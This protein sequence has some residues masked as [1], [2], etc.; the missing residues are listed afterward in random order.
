MSPFIDKVKIA[1]S[2][3]K[4]YP[5]SPKRDSPLPGTPSTKVGAA[6]QP[7]MKGEYGKL[8]VTPEGDVHHWITDE[9]GA[10]HHYQYAEDHGLTYKT[11]RPHGHATGY[12]DPDGTLHVPDQMYKERAEP[13]ARAALPETHPPKPGWI[14]S[15]VASV[16]VQNGGHHITNYLGSPSDSI[17]TSWKPG[18]RGKGL[19]LNDGLHMWNSMSD[20]FDPHHDGIYNH[21]R[22]SDYTDAVEHYGELNAAPKFYIDYDGT[23]DMSLKGDYDPD[24]DDRIAA[25]HPDLKVKDSGW[26]FSKIATV[27]ENTW[28]RGKWGKGLMLDGDAWFW[29][30]DRAGAPHHFAYNR[31]TLQ[32]GDRY[33]DAIPLLIKPDGYVDIYAFPTDGDMS[34]VEAQIKLFGDDWPRYMKPG[35]IGNFYQENKIENPYALPAP[36]DWLFSQASIADD[37]GIDEDEDDFDEDQYL[38]DEGWLNPMQTLDR[39]EPL[40]HVDHP[41]PSGEHYDTKPDDY[42]DVDEST[43][44][45]PVLFDGKRFYAGRVN[46]YH[47]D[48]MHHDP[49]LRAQSDQGQ[50]MKGNPLTALDDKD[51]FAYGR[52]NEKNNAITWYHKG[53]WRRD[54]LNTLTDEVFGSPDDQSEDM[55]FKDDDWHFGANE[56]TV[57]IQ[58]DKDKF[59]PQDFSAWY[60]PQSN[61]VDTGDQSMHHMDIEHP[62]EAIAFWAYNGELGTYGGAPLWLDRVAEWLQTQGAMTVLDGGG[63]KFAAQVTPQIKEVSES[64]MDDDSY[65]PS[66]RRPVLYY[67][68]HNTVLVGPHDSHHD[69]LYEYLGDD[70]DP[71]E[72][73]S[74]IM[75]DNKLRFW[76]DEEKERP[77]AAEQALMKQYG[78]ELDKDS[79]EWEFTAAVDPEITEVPYDTPDM[80]WPWVAQRRPFIYSPKHGTI[81]MTEFGGHHGGIHKWLK[82]NAPHVLD[83][84][85]YEGMVNTDPKTP[86]EG[87]GNGNIAY[88]GDVPGD[89]QLVQNAI[90]NKFPEYKWPD[91]RQEPAGNNEWMFGHVAGDHTD[92]QWAYDKTKVVPW[93]PEANSSGKFIVEPDGKVHHWVVDRHG[94]PHHFQYAQD[95]LGHKDIPI[96]DVPEDHVQGWITPSGGIDGWGDESLVQ[97]AKEAIHGHDQEDWVFGHTSAIPVVEYPGTERGGPGQL[98]PPMHGVKSRAVTYLNGI[99]HVGMP[100]S[101]H[102]FA[103]DPDNESMS[104]RIYPEE[105]VFEW[106]DNPGNVSDQEVIEALAPYGVKSVLDGVWHGGDQPSKVDEDLNWSYSRVNPTSQVDIANAFASPEDELQLFARSLSNLTQS[107]IQPKVQHGSQAGGHNSQSSGRR[108]TYQAGNASSELQPISSLRNRRAREED[109]ALGQPVT[110]TTPAPFKEPV[111]GQHWKGL[112]LNNGEEYRWWVDG[113]WGAPHHGDAMATLNIAPEE[114]ANYLDSSRD[115]KTGFD[116]DYGERTPSLQQPFVDMGKTNWTFS[117]TEQSWRPGEIGKFLVSPRGEVWS[118]ITEDDAAGGSPHHSDY[119][120]QHGLPTAKE[121]EADWLFGFIEP[122]GDYEANGPEES[123]RIAER[124]LGVKPMPD[125]S[126]TFGAVDSQTEGNRILKLTDGSVVEQDGAVSSHMMLAHEFGIHPDN[127]ADTG[128]IRNGEYEWDNTPGWNEERRNNTDWAFSKTANDWSFVE[129]PEEDTESALIL[130]DDTMRQ[131]NTDDYEAHHD[132]MKAHGLT[133]ADV[134]DYGWI[135]PKGHY[136]SLTGNYGEHQD[137]GGF[138]QKG[139][140]DYY[141]DAWKHGAT[142]ATHREAWGLKRKKPEP[143]D[144][145]FAPQ[146]YI[147]GVVMKNDGAVRSWDTEKTGEY[148]HDWLENNGIDPASVVMWRTDPYEDDKLEID[149]D[150]EKH[151]PNVLKHLQ[152]EHGIS[153]EVREPWTEKTDANEQYAPQVYSQHNAKEKQEGD[154]L[155]RE[156]IQPWMPRE[157]GKWLLDPYGKVHHWAYNGRG[158]PHHSDV[159]NYLGY[160]IADNWEEWPSGEIYPDGG[161]VQSYGS[162]RAQAMNAVLAQVQGTHAAEDKGDWTYSRSSHVQY[163]QDTQIGSNMNRANG[164]IRLNYR[165]SLPSIL[166]SSGES[167]QFIPWT[168]GNKGKYIVSPDNKVHHWT[169]DNKG[170]PHHE[171]WARAQ[172][173]YSEPWE[174]WPYGYIEPDGTYSIEPGMDAGYRER[175]DI[176]ALVTGQV[177]GTV[178]QDDMNTSDDWQFTSKRYAHLTVRRPSYKGFLVSETLAYPFLSIENEIEDTSASG[179][180]DTG[181]VTSWYTARGVPVSSEKAD[182]IFEISSNTHH[183][184][185]K[186]ANPPSVEL[187]YGTIE[188]W[189]KGKYGKAM[190]DPKGNIYAWATDVSSPEEDAGIV[191]GSPHHGEVAGILFG[192]NYYMMKITFVYMYPDGKV[193]R[194]GRDDSSNEMDIQKIADALGGYMPQDEDWSFNFSKTAAFA[195]PEGYEP[196]KP[197]GFGKAI[198]HNGNHYAWATDVGKSTGDPRNE[199]WIGAPHHGEALRDLDIRNDPVAKHYIYPDGTVDPSW[200]KDPKNHQYAAEIADHI[201]G[202]TGEPD[203]TFSKTAEVY[204]PIPTP[205]Y[206]VPKGLDPPEIGRWG[207]AINRRD[208]GD[209]YAWSTN[210]NGEPHHAYVARDELKLGTPPYHVDAFEHIVPWVIDDKGQWFLA[211]DV[212]FDWRFAKT[213][214]AETPPEFEPWTPGHDGKGLTVKDGTVYAWNSAG[215]G[216]GKR[217]H[218]YDALEAIYGIRARNLVL[219]YF[220]IRDDEIINSASPDPEHGLPPAV[221]ALGIPLKN[222]GNWTF[223]KIAK[224]E[225]PSVNHPEMGYRLMGTPQPWEPGMYGKGWVTPEGIVYLWGQHIA[226]AQSVTPHHA[227]MIPVTTGLA[228]YGDQAGQA[229][230]H[231]DKTFLVS[232][233]GTVSPSVHIRNV[234]EFIDTILA[235]DPRLK[236]EK[237]NEAWTFSRVGHVLGWEPGEEGRALKL[238][239]GTVHT[240]GGGIWDHGSIYHGDYAD[241]NGLEYDGPQAITD[242]LYIHNDGH[243]SGGDKDTNQYVQD[244]IGTQQPSGEDDWTFSKVASLPVTNGNLTYTEYEPP[245]GR[246]T[247]PPWEPGKKGKGILTENGIYFWAT[248]SLGAPHHG[249]INTTVGGKELGFCYINPDGSLRTQGRNQEVFEKALP[250]THTAPEQDWTFSRVAAEQRLEWTPGMYGRALTMGDGSIYTWNCGE[251]EGEVWSNAGGYHNAYINKHKIPYQPDTQYMYIEPNGA[252]TDG[253]NDESEM[254]V[255]KLNGYER[256]ADKEDDDWTFGKVAEQ[257]Q[258]LNLYP[259][260]PPAKPIEVVYDAGDEADDFHS[261]DHPFIYDPVQRKVWVGHEGAYHWDLVQHPELSPSYFYN[262]GSKKPGRAPAM[263]NRS[264]VNGRYNARNHNVEWFDDV[265]GVAKVPQK[266]KVEVESALGGSSAGESAWTFGKVAV[267]GLKQWT[268]GNL[269]KAFVTADGNA[270]AW[271][272]RPGKT[273]KEDGLP[274]HQD[275]MKASGYGSIWDAF[276]TWSF[277]Y[278]GADGT[279]DQVSDPEDD[280]AAAKRHNDALE[281]LGFKPAS[282]DASWSFSK[283][284]SAI[285]P[286]TMKPWSPNKEGKGFVTPDGK[287]YAWAVTVMRS[288]HHMDGWENVFGPWDPK[289]T[290]GPIA[291]FYTDRGKI[292][293]ATGGTDPHRGLEI[294]AQELGV[295][296]DNGTTT[297]NFARTAATKVIDWREDQLDDPLYSNHP[298]P[299]D[300]NQ[301]PNKPW[302]YNREKDEIHIGPDNWFHADLV[303]GMRDNW[304]NYNSSGRL[305]LAH[306]HGFDPE[307]E[308]IY[309]ALKDHYGYHNEDFDDGSS[310]DDRWDFESRVAVKALVPQGCRPWTRGED[311]RYLVDGHGAVWAWVADDSTHSEVEMDNDLEAVDGGYIT[312]DGK[313]LPWDGGEQNWIFSAVAPIKMKVV[314]PNDDNVDEYNMDDL[315]DRRPV[316]FNPHTRQGYIGDYGW[317]HTGIFNQEPDLDSDN[318]LA[319]T[320]YTDWKY[321]TLRDDEEGGHMLDWY[322][323]GNPHRDDHEP[324]RAAISEALGAPVTRRDTDD[325]WTFGKVA[326]IPPI[327]DYT[328][329]NQQLNDGR[330]RAVDGEELWELLREGWTPGKEGKGLL[331]D[332]E[333]YTWNTTNDMG[334]PHH[335]EMATVLEAAGVRIRQPF[336]IDAIYPDGGIETNESAY[337]IVH[338]HDP[339]LHK[340]EQQSMFDVWNFR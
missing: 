198:T 128:W 174:D 117:G 89:K 10:P 288:A 173:I 73:Y 220:Y 270:V 38:E 40:R 161:V 222:E 39:S 191:W 126:W 167:H 32:L 303:R 136:V 245:H 334:D 308:K 262:D 283:V 34:R 18:G 61:S 86:S 281:A 107:D 59:D 102:G 44:E 37:V 65:P 298:R 258:M 214:S 217:D 172:G 287:V 33:Y 148:H 72:V 160:T 224:V 144:Y 82:A 331:T 15:K 142:V 64:T 243:V 196:W 53:K 151:A 108:N 156:E 329:V 302:L 124:E 8:L 5:P 183:Y 111:P 146:H 184:A 188:P 247:A 335:H 319:D 332:G 1:P 168:P 95:Y 289:V 285:T 255:E 194:A 94:A 9:N 35:N 56:L 300:S 218:H 317:H 106:Y 337:D 87:N 121:P 125:K 153:P 208:N 55:G 259:D 276:S 175:D 277:Y 279:Y 192:P 210:G 25:M 264:L 29:G 135:H 312:P 170:F 323:H 48:M 123:K 200:R 219:A 226:E 340:A 309:E 290:V 28:Q 228:G 203:W 315:G 140:W 215:D 328:R 178:T 110:F 242:H 139:N 122:N 92:D 212:P 256:P 244:V 16:P 282:S 145:T 76:N 235:A 4:V 230:E 26:S 294:A 171:Q 150:Q 291:W 166:H 51:K 181:Q 93:T 90:F 21:L 163:L 325:D 280:P 206:E 313:K 58:G 36:G 3:P 101:Y 88:W 67:P 19:L 253:W 322:S 127:I 314:E 339:R 43:H 186:L 199:A 17:T 85:Y 77:R 274:S 211:E 129:H 14:F 70:W 31:D 295:S 267:R 50:Y 12:L 13:I 52:W 6:V 305:P 138:G 318:Y 176:H 330:S 30:V 114:T 79:D 103:P 99:F 7:W 147:R 193:V 165:R 66:G 75:M 202:K 69:P 275:A 234:D 236:A 162:S 68:P 119:I 238:K 239:D 141:Q 137:D 205:E 272:I 42:G 91:D 60:D 74:G 231:F 321:G 254:K 237:G 133:P 185:S 284:A 204:K 100:S 197:G 98:G 152:Q 216:M 179:L 134:K 241:R 221:E 306:E 187:R 132:Y 320:D 63:W 112:I 83:D 271:A 169:Y 261:P 84:E 293:D 307:R 297:W 116:P 97:K 292:E 189:H 229:G 130:H 324:L 180:A 260:P 113:A 265:P 207:K 23:I 201:G 278:I 286:R 78:V 81:H 115:M 71:G 80:G 96:G 299:T 316:V 248:D 45:R 268:P 27:M 233:D 190:M 120:E 158:F 227:D 2:E 22:G 250:G 225:L 310:F 159:A 154:P 49:D 304:R 213:A 273:V 62:P 41:T 263:V 252:V 195:V 149:E 232:P 24:I 269:G 327:A 46:A 177:P 104:A 164:L 109:E 57:R 326:A 296:L 131:W 105:G 155:T 301:I 246:I 336:Y 223:G 118:W 251:T 249:D 209:Y 266:I 143:I 157:N 47:W 54:H 240:W 311:G 20:S 257:L 338:Q 182:P 11:F 333:L